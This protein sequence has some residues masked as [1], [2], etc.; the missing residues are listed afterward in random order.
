MSRDV[1]LDAGAQPFKLLVQVCL[2]LGSLLVTFLADLSR[3]A[4]DEVLGNSEHPLV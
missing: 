3:R 2:Q 4:E 1:L